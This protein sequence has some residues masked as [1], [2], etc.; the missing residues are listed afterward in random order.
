MATKFPIGP[1]N[2]QAVV[3]EGKQYVWDGVRWELTALH[4]T[5]TN[6]LP[7]AKQK[8]DVEGVGRKIEHSFTIKRLDDLET[9]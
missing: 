9:I 2:G 3:I 8:T 7:V 1:S 5:F 6:T 4:D